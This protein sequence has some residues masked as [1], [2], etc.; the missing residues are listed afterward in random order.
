[1]RVKAAR[2]VDIVH[3]PPFGLRSLMNQASE[4][5]EVYHK[6]VR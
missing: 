1:M 5:I 3:T 6:F 2:P 4:W